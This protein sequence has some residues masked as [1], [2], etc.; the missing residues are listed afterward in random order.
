LSRV[1][2]AVPPYAEQ[3]R[4]VEAIEAA[5]RWHTSESLLL[6]KLNV[7]KSGLMDDLLTGRIRATPLLA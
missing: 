4:I 6:S 3:Q 7:Q 2:V 5:D 1:L